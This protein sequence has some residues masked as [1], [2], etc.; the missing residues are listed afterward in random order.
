MVVVIIIPIAFYG[1][2][3][4]ICGGSPIFQEK[5][6]V[7]I[8]KNNNDAYLNLL[9]HFEATG[10]YRY[11]YLKGSTEDDIEFKEINT[12]NK[13]IMAWVFLSYAIDEEGKVYEHTAKCL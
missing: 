6:F 3:Y 10:N 11:D 5:T 12:E 8:T 4:S 13:R 9:K 2:L 1:I 7:N